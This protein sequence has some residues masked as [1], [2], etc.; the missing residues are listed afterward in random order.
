[1]IKNLYS[2]HSA[3]IKL[4]A[5]RTIMKFARQ[6]HIV[7]SIVPKPLTRQY[8]FSQAET[9]RDFPFRTIPSMTRRFSDPLERDA[10]RQSF[11]HNPFDIR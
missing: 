3:N 10:I 1:M 9:E 7:V 11:V 2:Q 5:S 4:D 8:L 6:C